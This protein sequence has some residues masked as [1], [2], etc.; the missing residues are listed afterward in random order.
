MRRSRHPALDWDTIGQP[1][2]DRIIEALVQ[3]IYGED[4]DVRPIDGSGGDGGIDI[5]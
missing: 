2:F 1:L 3:R 5:E 4:W